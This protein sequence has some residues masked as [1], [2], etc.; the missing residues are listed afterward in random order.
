MARL[1]IFWTATA[2]KQR[3]YIFEYWI[4]K[5]G[6]RTYVSKLNSKIKER[7]KLLSSNPKLGKTANY[8][9]T[10]LLSLGHYSIYY[11]IY[12]AQIIITA[13]WDNRQDPLKLTEFLNQ[14]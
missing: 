8:N 13:F 5:N 10:R 3:D 6:N 11:Q 7:I 9:N 2:I 1:K 4:K 14:K 12:Y